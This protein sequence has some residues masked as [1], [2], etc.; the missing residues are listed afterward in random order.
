MSQPSESSEMKCQICQQQEASVYFKQVHNGQVRE[1]RVCVDCAEA[2][3]FSVQSPM[4]LTDFLFGE[5]PQMEVEPGSEDRLCP[6]CGM[7]LAE[8]RR[9]MRLGCAVCYE[10]FA[11][12]FS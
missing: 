7:S 3:G 8:M 6:A 1:L 4:A 10:A 12:E 2:N 9:R 11:E 5:G